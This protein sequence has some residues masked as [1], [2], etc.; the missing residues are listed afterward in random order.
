MGKIQVLDNNT[1]DQIAAGEVV[2]R[3]ASVVKELTENAIDA[4]ADA[5]TVEIKNGGIEFIRV[6]DNGCGIAKE[7]METAFLRHATSKIR[8][9]ED[10]RNVSSMG[11]RGEALA[12]IASV[13]KVT[14]I[15]KP[16]DSLMGYRLEVDGGVAGQ[17]TEVGAPGGTTI[18]AAH[19]FYNIPVRRKFLKSATTEGNVI[20]ELMEHLA[21]SRPDISFKLV[22]NGRNVFYTSGSGDLQNVIYRIY[23]RDMAKETIAID[24]ECDGIVIDGCLGTPAVNRP[25]RNFE[26]Y[27]L[28]KRYIKNDIVAR[29]LED[30]YKGYTMQ[31]KFPFCVLHIDMPAGDVDVNV[32]PGKMDVR[33]KDREG[34]Y[35]HI[36]KAVADALHS[37]EMIPEAEIDHERK[38][39][40]PEVAE[41]PE[42]YE[43]GRRSAYNEKNT[44]ES[45]ANDAAPELTKDNRDI[46]TVDFSDDEDVV[47][48]DFSK[49]RAESENGQNTDSSPADNERPGTEDKNPVYR[50]AVQL[51]ILPKERVISANARKRYELIGPAFNTY[52]MFTYDGK[53]YFADQHAAHEKV[54]Y[55]RLIKKYKEREIYKQQLNPPIIVNLSGEER[56]VLEKFKG[57]FDELGFEVN[58]FGGMDYALNTIPLESYRKDAK[59]FF[60]DILNDLCLRGVRETPDIIN[61]IMASIACKSAVKGGDVIS[62]EEMDK[63]LDELLTLD[64]PYHCP[65]G[66]PTVFSISRTELEKKFK[67]IVS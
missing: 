14:M 56:E 58:N 40:R 15:T 46:F 23:G 12:S 26:N 63:I 50:N 55:E 1:I 39:Y 64:N 10:L 24:Y 4:G 3:P 37:H 32:H 16:K 38:L 8:S 49:E 9:I 42:P 5:I 57:Y 19:L 67:R 22:S 34:M 43:A 53:L 61:K 62:R 47:L 35:E 52:W 6:T 29:G 44:A 2:E 18:I 60:M 66:R 11:F 45:S 41:A 31:H 17:V 48:Q 25:N 30:G 27:F 20:T 7:D 54:N 65:H 21:L 59:T 36:A 33:F 28:N 51:E 13:S